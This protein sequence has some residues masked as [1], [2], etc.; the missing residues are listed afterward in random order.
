MNNP[1]L[2]IVFLSLGVLLFGY[3]AFYL[4]SYLKKNRVKKGEECTIPQKVYKMLLVLIASQGLTAIGSTY[5][6]ALWFNWNVEVIDHFGFILGSYFFASGFS[7][8]F[9]SFVLYYYRPTMVKEERKRVRIG[10]F[11]SIPIVIIFCLIMMNSIGAYAVYPLPNAIDFTYGLTT[12]LDPSGGFRIAFYGIVVVFGAIMSYFISDHYFY[13][14]YGKHGLIDTLFLVAFPAG[15]IGARLW[16]CLVLEPARYLADPVT[17][18]YVMDGGLAVQ[19]GAILG[20]IAGIA[21]MRLFRKYVDIRFAMDVC[22][23]TILIAQ[24]I[25]RWGNF[26]NCEVHG[27]AVD[28]SGWSFLPNFILGQLQF[29]S[30]AP[31]LVGTN[32]IY[33]PLFLIESLI[34]FGGYFLI[35]YATKGINKYLPL[36]AQASMYL[37]WYG[38]VRLILEPFRYGYNG[39]T[40]SDAFGYSQ[41]FVTAIVMLSGGALL[42]GAFYLWA[43]LEKKK[44]NL[45]K[46]KNFNFD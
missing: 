32:Q 24:A 26:F 23:P 20:I 1:A 29:S 12:I 44:K 11:S 4:I 15:L 25:G 27:M 39:T 18:F 9:V 2:F 3:L 34:N 42:L 22:I 28:M 35:R 40:T 19:G 10:L 36:G 16:Y 17:I 43:Y 46:I 30:E 38:V 8:L 45:D 41:S 21:F 33:V 6:L 13:K 37:I 31:S 7:L 5:G 14:K